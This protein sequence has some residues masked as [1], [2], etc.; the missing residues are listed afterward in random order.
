MNEEDNDCVACSGT[1]EGHWSNSVCIV[2]KGK[3]VVKTND[4]EEYDLD[5]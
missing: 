2:C 5:D 3:G 4:W 1:G